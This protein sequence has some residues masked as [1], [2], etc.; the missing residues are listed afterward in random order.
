MRLTLQRTVPALFA[1][2]IAGGLWLEAI[3]ATQVYKCVLDGKVTFQSDPCQSGPPAERPTVEQLNRERLRKQREAAVAPAAQLPPVPSP[4]AGRSEAPQAPAAP[5][6]SGIRPPEP[7]PV[8]PAAA[9]FRCD[10]RKYC[11]QMTSCQEAKYFLATCPGVRMDG[12]R[13][14]IPCEEQWCT[15]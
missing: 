11:S 14:G 5:A 7:S 9:S 8:P 10:G 12:D 6:R 3:A 13:D 1:L 15:P 2:A 4:A